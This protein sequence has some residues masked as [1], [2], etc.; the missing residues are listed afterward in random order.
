MNSEA[1]ANREKRYEDLVLRLQN[2]N[3]RVTKFRRN[4][5]DLLLERE[6]FALSV[7]EMHSLS[8][9]SSPDLVTVY[10][11]VEAL[12]EIGV[13]DRASDGK[14]PARYR[15]NEGNESKLKVSCRQCHA[16]LVSPSPIIFELEKVAREFGYRELIANCE[17]TGYCEDCREERASKMA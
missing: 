5:I 17:I 3:L 1:D 6:P 12:T 13:L 7:E 9:S 2:A 4:L 10:R 15:L 14:G 16:T 11:N 8:V